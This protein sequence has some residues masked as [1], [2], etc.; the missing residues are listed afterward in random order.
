MKT[1]STKLSVNQVKVDGLMTFGM[2]ETG[3]RTLDFECC[4]YVE[5][6][7]FKCSFH[8]QGMHDGNVHMVQRAKRI[9]ARP[10]FR[11]DNS[12]LT[13]GKNDR[14]YFCFSI[15]KDQIRELP[16]RLVRQASI[17]AQKVLREIICKKEVTA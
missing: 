4:E 5:T 14:Y 7:P 9:K 6:E 2:L 3:Q 12:S 15:P 11:D 17:I 13:L 8:V 10:L 1:K 16:V